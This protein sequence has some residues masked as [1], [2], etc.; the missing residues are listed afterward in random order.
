VFGPPKTKAS[1]RVVPLSQATVDVA[2]ARLAKFGAGPGGVLFTTTRGTP[3]RRNR[4][5]NAWSKVRVRAGLPDAVPHDLRHHFASV[6]IGAGCSLK[7]VQD[8]LGHANASETLD[9]YSHLWPADEDRIRAAVDA[10]L[11]HG[12]DQQALAR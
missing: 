4:L 12:V 11:G 2:A 6:L 5:N 9:T 3:L 7:A 1:M 10:A 8:A